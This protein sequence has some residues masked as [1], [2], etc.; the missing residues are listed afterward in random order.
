MNVLVSGNAGPSAKVCGGGRLWWSTYSVTGISTAAS[1][2]SSSSA[3]RYGQHPDAPARGRSLVDH[4]HLAAAAL[5][6]KEPGREGTELLL[7]GD[8]VLCPESVEVGGKQCHSGGT[9][10]RRL[11]ERCPISEGPGSIGDGWKWRRR[12]TEQI[13]KAR[14]G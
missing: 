1:P 7:H 9:S 4:D 12:Q 14:L 2:F 6:A 13:I 10:D 5:D 3:A 8:R 11:V